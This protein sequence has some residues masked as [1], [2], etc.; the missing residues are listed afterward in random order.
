MNIPQ[1]LDTSTQPQ[2][3]HKSRA[4]LL[5]AAL[6]VIRTKGYAATTVDDICHQA[7]VTKGSF[8][9][10]F[11]SKDDLALAAVKYWEQMTGGFFASAPYHQPQDPL[12]RLLGYLDFREA[13][14][15][16]ELPD[17]TCLLGT[18]V[19]ET[20]DTHPHIRAACEQA[21]SSHIAALAGDVKAAKHLYAPKARWTAEGVATYIQA[22]LQGSFIFAKA[23]QTPEIIRENIE[24][25]RRYLQFLFPPTASTQPARKIPAERKHKPIA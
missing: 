9:H 10:H 3:A 4:R 19:Q 20:Y 6:Q 7:G 17:Y 1:Q 21:L 14:L 16:G 15:T 24:H 13:I 12:A 2:A 25:L 22:V 11:K 18:L 8:F 5:D 23:R